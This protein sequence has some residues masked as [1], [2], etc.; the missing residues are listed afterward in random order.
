MLS[1]YE[2]KAYAAWDKQDQI[3]LI[4]N[5]IKKLNTITYENY[6]CNGVLR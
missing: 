4:Q 5:E 3:D 2:S 6:H 1:Y